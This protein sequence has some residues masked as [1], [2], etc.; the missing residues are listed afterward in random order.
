MWNFK[1]SEPASIYRLNLF[2]IIC[3]GWASYSSWD[4]WKIAQN[5][6]HYNR[7]YKALTFNRSVFSLLEF[8][9]FI[10]CPILALKSNRKVNRLNLFHYEILHIYSGYIFQILNFKKRLRTYRIPVFFSALLL[11][12]F[13]AHHSVFEKVNHEA[14]VGRMP[15]RCKHPLI[16]FVTNM[17]D[18]KIVGKFLA[19][20]F[21]V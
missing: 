11:V 12:H 4:G 15:S 17:N 1:K 19:S 10:L 13:T 5:Q 21:P 7:I 8:A 3:A 6:I 9:S 20:S 16:A 18:S 2:K 14:I